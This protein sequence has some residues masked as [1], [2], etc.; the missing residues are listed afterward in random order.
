MWLLCNGH[1]FPWH[2]K[3]LPNLKITDLFYI[4][5][6]LLT[7]FID[8]ILKSGNSDSY[9]DLGVQKYMTIKF[10]GDI[11]EIFIFL[12]IFNILF[13]FLTCEVK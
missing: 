12:R 11:A 4:P 13:Q 3:N 2:K 5:K 8:V 10:N 9:S 6:L 1:T 7:I